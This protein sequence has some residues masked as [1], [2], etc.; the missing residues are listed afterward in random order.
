MDDIRSVKGPNVK[1]G[2]NMKQSWMESIK[3][4]QRTIESRFQ[5]LQL[6]GEPINC[7]SVTYMEV[8][9]FERHLKGLFPSLYTTKLQITDGEESQTDSQASPQTLKTVVLLAQN[10][11][12]QVKRVE[13]QKPW[14]IYCNKTRHKMMLA[15]N[16]SDFE[17]TFW[18]SLISPRWKAKASLGIAAKAWSSMCN[19]SGS[20]LLREWHQEKIYLFPLWNRKRNLQRWTDEKIQNGTAHMRCLRVRKKSTIYEETIWKINNEAKD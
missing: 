7:A 6:K 15:K 8:P 20:S 11:R 16:F 4:V 1:Q 18:F 19:A 14:V 17:F 2:P 13:C 3:P 9:I 12:A 5:R 10:A